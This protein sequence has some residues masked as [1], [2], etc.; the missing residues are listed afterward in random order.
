MNWILA[1]ENGEK[2]SL[3]FDATAMDYF[4]AKKNAFLWIDLEN[5]TPEEWKIADDAFPFH[6]LSVE[7]CQNPKLSTPKI[8]AFTDHLFIVVHRFFYE[9][10]TVKFKELDVFLGTNYIVTI[11]RESEPF[12]GRT[13]GRFERNPELL[14]HGTEFVLHAIL[15]YNT[16]SLF[17]V[18]EEWSRDIDLLEEQVLQEKGNNI[19]STV[20]YLKKRFSKLKKGIGPQSDVVR[21]LGRREFAQ[22]SA[23]ATTYF[24]DVYDHLWRINNELESYRDT[25]AGLFEAYLSVISNRMNEQN[26]KLNEIMKKLTALSTIFLP[27]T[28]IASIYGMNFQTMPELT[29]PFGYVAVLSLMIIVGVGI[30]VYLRS[31]KWL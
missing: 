19:V 7:E 16:D 27:L 15:D 20:L 1:V 8:D 4:L 10:K 6:P 25:T 26:V 14:G 11:H 13:K 28:F 2:T 24:N 31:K 22:V 17:G 12:I 23:S 5:P 9:K 29:H 30:A 18:L 3:A 21:R